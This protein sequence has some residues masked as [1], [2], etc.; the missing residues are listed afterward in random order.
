MRGVGLR[1]YVDV[2]MTAFNILL[3]TDLAIRLYQHDHG[4][5]P[6]TLEDLVPAYLPKVPPDPLVSVPIGSVYM[7]SHQPLSYRVENAQFILYSLGYLGEDNG[8]HFGNEIQGL[9]HSGYDVDV[10]TWTRP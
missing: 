2:E 6:K 9:H 4:R 1:G 3:Q 10:E 8:G 7:G 5:F